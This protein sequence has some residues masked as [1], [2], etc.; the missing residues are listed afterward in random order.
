MSNLRKKIFQYMNKYGTSECPPHFK[1]EET[2]YID[3]NTAMEI[4]AMYTQLSVLQDMYEKEVDYNRLLRKEN[5][6]LAAELEDMYA[7]DTDSDDG[8]NTSG[9][10]N[11]DGYIS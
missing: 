7:Q 8:Q 10:L 3:H 9:T 4:A 11:G 1:F 2:T 5:Q 6:E